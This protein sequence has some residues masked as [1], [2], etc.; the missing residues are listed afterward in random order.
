MVIVLVLLA[1][2]YFMARPLTRLTKVLSEQA[3]QVSEAAHAVE[4]GGQSIAQDA[5]H[6]ASWLLEETSASME[7]LLAMTRRNTDHADRAS[8]LAHQTT[9][10][11][12]EGVSSMRQMR[13]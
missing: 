8:G 2:R 7:E 12:D 13:S 3:Q 9:T 6:Q 4:D 11:A 10:S 1:L 5:S